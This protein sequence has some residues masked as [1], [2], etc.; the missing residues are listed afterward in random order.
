MFAIQSKTVE[1]S[2]VSIG[3]LMQPEH[4]NPPG[5]IHG[6]E[7]MKLMDNA[8]AIVALR[9][10]RTNVATKRVDQLVFHHPVHVGDFVICNAQL[11][12]VGKSSME[13]LVTVLVDNITKDQPTKVALTAFFTLVALDGNGMPADA[14]PL[15]IITEEERVLFEAGRQRYLSYKQQ[16][17]R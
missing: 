6:G 9:H 13:V 5:N 2:K 14:P 17:L 3:N 8:A 15:A 10:T 16:R 1:Q 4:A 11:T 7:I 12:F